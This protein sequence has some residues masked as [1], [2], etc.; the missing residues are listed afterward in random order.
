MLRPIRSLSLAACRA[1]NAAGLLGAVGFIVF[2]F[3][4]ADRAP[5]AGVEVTA[6]FLKVGGLSTG[7]DVRISGVKVGTVTGRRLDTE[8]FEAVV[9]LTVSPTVQLPM[10]TEVIITNDGLL[11]GKYLRLVPGTAEETVAAG[12]EL[13]NT[14]D[15]RSLEDTVSE[16]IFLATGG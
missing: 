4:T 8:T 7:S 2:A 15:F 16:I 12:G 1:A 9:T 5:A 11:G 6:R 14:K 3:R 13:R 10:D